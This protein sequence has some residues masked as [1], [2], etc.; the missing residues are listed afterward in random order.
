MT[1]CQ[2]SIIN[3]GFKLF[4][5]GPGMII[6]TKDFQVDLIDEE[7]IDAIVEIYN[8]NR[9]FLMSHMDKESVTNKWLFEELEDM[10]AVKFNSY[11]VLDVATKKIIGFADFKIEDE[12][13]LS[14]FMLHSDYKKKGLGTLIYKEL[15]EYFISRKCREI[16][17]DVVTNYSTSV[18]DF[19]ERNGF[20]SY[21]E[22]QLNW[23]GKE[24]PAVIMKKNLL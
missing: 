1:N 22:V 12:V 21:E 17:I 4:S 6:K 15:E 19:W 8:S 13:Y 18:M 3:E 14:L 7:D 23:T 11:K 16:R 5:G 20:K 2:C 9:L 10:K 24:L